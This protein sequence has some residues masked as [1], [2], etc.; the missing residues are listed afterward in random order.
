MLYNFRAQ[1][2]YLP[3]PFLHDKITGLMCV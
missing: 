1:A 3:G 2:G